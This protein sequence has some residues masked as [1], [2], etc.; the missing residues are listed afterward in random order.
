LPF[1]RTVRLQPKEMMD[2]AGILDHFHIYFLQLFVC[3][4]F[5]LFQTYVKR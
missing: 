2:R 3:F 4:T 1:V 5:Y